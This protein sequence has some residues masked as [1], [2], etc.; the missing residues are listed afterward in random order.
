MTSLA[1]DGWG[2]FQHRTKE[3]RQTEAVC[4]TWSRS[5]LRGT[6]W[7]TPGVAWFRRWPRDFWKLVGR[8]RPNYVSEKASEL[9]FCTFVWQQLAPG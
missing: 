6:K 4:L 9:T 2:R 3:L 1:M 7:R 5:V 8:R